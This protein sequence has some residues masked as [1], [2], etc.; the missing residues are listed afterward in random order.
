MARKATTTRGRINERNAG[1]K[2]T[3][4]GKRRRRVVCKARP[5]LASPASRRDAPQGAISHTLPTLR[6]LAG[7]NK[8]VKLIQLL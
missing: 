8:T 1:K 4:F 2:K 6:D 3:L 7:L 5:N